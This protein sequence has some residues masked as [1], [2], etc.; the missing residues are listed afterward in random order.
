MTGSKAARAPA[1]PTFPLDSGPQL[2]R[3]V[4]VTQLFF[5]TPVPRPCLRPSQVPVPRRLRT[6]EGGH[7]TSCE[8]PSRGDRRIKD[9]STLS[10]LVCFFHEWLDSLASVG[11]SV[12]TDEAEREIGEHSPSGTCPEP[13]TDPC[14]KLRASEKPRG[15]FGYPLPVYCACRCCCYCG[16][17]LKCQRTLCVCPQPSVSRTPL[18]GTW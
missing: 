5:K 11:F 14:R 1:S 13:L 15:Y 8:A 16:V 2:W 3:C 12:N 7:P 4:S 18:G 17:T 10:A 6:P 9:R